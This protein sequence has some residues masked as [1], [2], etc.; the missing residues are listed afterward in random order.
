MSYVLNI[1]AV[2]LTL[3]SGGTAKYALGTRGFCNDS[4]YQYVSCATAA[5]AVNSLVKIDSAYAISVSNNTSIPSAKV[6]KVGVVQTAVPAGTTTTQY[7]WVFV[8]PGNCTVLCAASCVQDVQLLTTN[9]D[10]VVDDAGT[11]NIM[12]LKLIT[13]IVGAAASACFATHE[14][15]TIN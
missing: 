8:G 2:D 11:T 12:G 14:L 6:H 3:W 5:I 13:T 9:T 15:T 4:V 1:P 10:G 7:G